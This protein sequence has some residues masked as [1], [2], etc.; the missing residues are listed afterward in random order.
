MKSGKLRFQP[1]I[2]RL[3]DRSGEG[4]PLGKPMS[5][6]LPAHARFDGIEF[7][8]PAQRLGCHRRAGRLAAFS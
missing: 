4:A 3:H 7:A 1:G 5:G 8:D 6:R 2:Q